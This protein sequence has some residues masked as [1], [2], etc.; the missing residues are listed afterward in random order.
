MPA[1]RGMVVAKHSIAAEIGAS[2]LRQGGNAFDAA[3]AMGFALGVVEPYMSGIGGGTLQLVYRD[4]HRRLGAVDAPVVTP[5]GTRSGCY[6]IDPQSPRGLFGFPGVTNQAN[7]IGHQS[8]AVPG[9]LA[10]L[11]F[12]LERFGTR[13]LPE[14]MQPAIRLAE[15]G[16][17]LSWIDIVHLAADYEKLIRFPATAAIFLAAGRVPVP[18]LQYPLQPTHALV[19][20]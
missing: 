9:V 18:S 2:F 8:V 3:V 5:A 12:T 11:C 7:E 15:H 20:R 10:G 17:P 16:Y 6:T 13:S 14:V 1:A 4:A 19:Q